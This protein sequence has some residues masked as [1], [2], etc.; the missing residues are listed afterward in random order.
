[1]AALCGDNHIEEAKCRV[2]GKWTV[3]KNTFGK[4]NK[5]K[6]VEAAKTEATKF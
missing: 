5:T 1:M 4:K 3:L 2:G 6:T